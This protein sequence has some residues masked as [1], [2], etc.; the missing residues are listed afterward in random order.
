MR[1]RGSVV[2]YAATLAYVAVGLIWVDAPWDVKLGALG[3]FALVVVVA[4]ALDI[5]LKRRR[6]RPLYEQA[7]ERATASVPARS[8]FDRQRPIL[9]VA[10]GGRM[11][12]W[13]FTV[14]EVDGGGFVLVPL[15][16]PG[17]W[18]RMPLVQFE[19][20]THLRRAV[21]DGDYMMLPQSD[22]SD[23]AAAALSG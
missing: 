15:D 9:M 23:A 8:K 11:N 4:A 22:F 7:S 2:F 10:V 18:P 14:E 20:W 21:G 17:R 5:W 16:G 1:W 3:V 13:L 12:R 19:S 6:P